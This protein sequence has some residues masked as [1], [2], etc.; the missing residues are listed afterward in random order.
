M[1]TTLHNSS[2]ADA[3]NH[4]SITDCGKP[5]RNCDGRLPLLLDEAIERCLHNIF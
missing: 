5:V 2:L 1:G 3:S 4:L